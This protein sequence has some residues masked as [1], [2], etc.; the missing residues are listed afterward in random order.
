MPD[1]QDEV[2][3]AIDDVPPRQAERGHNET[4]NERHDHKLYQCAGEGIAEEPVHL[5]GHA[6]S[7][8]CPW[9]KV[10]ACCLQALSGIG[11]FASEIGLEFFCGRRQ[12]RAT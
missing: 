5:I 9:N 7:P 4:D 10:A 12:M 8:V 6:P 3:E 2:A 11:R 1:L